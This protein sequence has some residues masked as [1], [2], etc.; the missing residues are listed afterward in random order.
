MVGP[1]RQLAVAAIDQ[2]GE[3]DRLRPAEVDQRVHRRPDRPARVQHVVDEDDR[4]AIDARRQRRA[5]DDRLLG[6]HRQVVAVERDVERPDRDLDPLVLGDRGRDPAG[7][8][9]AATLDPDEQQAVGPGLLLDDLV[10]Q[11]DRRAADLVRGHD[12][13]AA[14]RSFPASP[15]LPGGLTGPWLKGQEEGYRARGSVAGQ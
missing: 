3:A 10:G 13:T 7:E 4:P 11:A 5:L 2:D 9:D 15:G 6:D 12:L 1:D 8:R 14:H